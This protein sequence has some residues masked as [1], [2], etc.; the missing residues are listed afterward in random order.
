VSP[1]P[2]PRLKKV[3]MKETPDR[4]EKIEQ[5]YHAALERDEAQRAGYLHEA[6]GEDEAL[7]REVESLLAQETQ[8]GGLLESLAID[9]AAKMLAE[10][11]T[12]SLVGHQLGSFK[13]LSLLG[14]GGMGEVYQAHDTKLGRD[15]AIKILPPAF[16]HDADRLARFQ[17]E[18]KLL[19]SLN[20][21]NIATIYGLEQL[22]GVHYLVMELIPGQTLAERITKGVL[23]QQ[24][25]LKI[26]TQIAEALEAAHEKGVIHWDLK[27]ANVK[28][29]PE[30]RVKV[31]DFGLAKAFGGDGGQDLS[32]AP[33]LSEE[34]RILGTPSYMSPEQARGKPVD[35]RTDIWAFGCLLY[36]L[37]TAKQAFHGE[38]FSDSIATVLERE[39]DWQALPSST[40]A[41]IHDLL[42]RCLQKDPQHRLRDIGDAR[43]ELKESLTEPGVT[44]PASVPFGA[45]SGVPHK[46]G[47]VVRL[48]AIALGLA[49][50]LAIALA[51][52]I[53]TRMLKS[54]GAPKPVSRLTIVLP[55][56]QRLAGTLVGSPVALSHD[57]THLAYVAR[58]GV[59]QR[60][61]LRSMDS[62]TAAPIAGTQGA[63]TPSFSP[64][65]QWLIF[66]A[67]GKLKKISVNGGSALTLGDS[68]LPAG[69]SWSSQGIIGF[70]FYRGSLLQV[71]EGGGPA[72]P[73]TRLKEG[74]SGQFSPEFL[75]GGKAV[76][77]VVG[78]KAGSSKAQIAVQSLTT[79]ERRDLVEGIQPRYAAS[80]HLIYA[81]SGT[82]M[83]VPFD[84]QQ[85]EVKGDPVAV[86]EDVAES[87]TFSMSQYSISD[88]GSLVYISAG[89]HNVQR[90][91]VW[92]DRDGVEQPLPAPTRAYENLRLSPDGRRI[93]M[94]IDQQIWIYDLARET[95]SRLTFEGS[96]N[97]LPLWTPD[98]KRIAFYSD[99]AAG[100]YNLWW[101]LS[102]GSGRLE[103]LTTDE[104]ANNPETFSPDGHL[105]AFV[106]I[107]PNTQWDIWILR[108]GD[109]KPTPFLRTPFSE[110][111]P[112][113]SPDGH[114]LAYVSNES[115]RPEV[116]VQ[117][118]PGPGGKYPISTD[119]GTEPLWNHNGRELFF[120]NGNKMMAVDVTTAPDFS[121]GR[122][123]LLFEGEYW[124]NETPTQRSAY[125]VSPDGQRFL[126][127]KP[128][129]AS[130]D[131]QI[132]VVLNWFEEL[133]R[134]VPTWRP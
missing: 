88:S 3:V 62:Q 109:N 58:E 69:A 44:A 13:I 102:D 81:Q 49:A 76:V 83:A 67:D 26:A 71:P 110:G 72:Q 1:L 126:M 101:Q 32:L 86:V 97:R 5:L 28:V 16:V 84:T 114:W 68:V 50:A 15:V 90:R 27:P 64:D 85:L 40:P 104:Y 23:P 89:A 79:G 41:K 21:P 17:R 134:R 47:N 30:G 6:C 54:G 55:R 25:A 29:T 80:G 12:H 22:E 92:V 59:E 131:T 105:L 11:Q 45:P 132:N 100:E 108:I 98:G 117:P 128:T 94:E 91:M 96:L 31:L 107:N 113:F 2:I 133:K 20:H 60:L 43:I 18:A 87:P 61:Y 52:L 130:S 38:T 122:P 103:R 129:E 106:E 95:L 127:V 7:R 42:R 24:E 78:S 34:G 51:G 57:G 33:T 111:A 39:P 35:K 48:R 37:L 8:A 36:E 56:G 124:A 19:A 118:Y 73:L 93:A 63:V 125:D 99:K 119:G 123:R 65:G 115:G 77:F 121:V 82:L 53:A 4:W 9:M 66:F 75:P 14:L 120:R 112:A 74:D 116:Y 46:D 70:G 10:N